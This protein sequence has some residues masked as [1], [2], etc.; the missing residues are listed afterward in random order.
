MNNNCVN[1]YFEGINAWKNTKIA[2]FIRVKGIVISAIITVLL[3]CIFLTAKPFW[4]DMI[5]VHI[6]L[7]ILI[8]IIAIGLILGMCYLRKRTLRSL[9]TKAILHEFAHYIR[10][11]HSKWFEYSHTHKKNI[12]TSDYME[13]ANKLAFYSQKYF[14]QITNDKN[15]GVAIRIALPSDTDNENE[16]V[17]Y[18]T[19]AR[20]G[21]NPKREDTSENIYANEGI[22]N[23]LI[24]KNKQ[25]KVIIY[26]DINAAIINDLFKETEN[27]KLYKGEIET[28]M[29]APLNAWD[30]KNKNRMIGILYITSKD[31]N[32][33]QE[34]HVD[35]MRY[36]AD[37]IAN[38]LSITAELY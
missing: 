3:S 8:I 38:S 13:Y 5:S 21:L 18:K 2:F 16:N 37:K 7:A 35:C 11:I 10:D 29:V 1:V 25:C 27:E 28:M 9:N 20:I 4:L 22:P 17:L 15:I 36:I 19:I 30:G 34:Q 33:F 14:T 26:N 23:Y 12:S 31:N 32:I 24:T 6:V